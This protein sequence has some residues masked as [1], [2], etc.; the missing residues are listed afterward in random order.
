MTDTSSALFMPFTTRGVTFKNRIVV[1]PM[2]QYAA[3]DGHATDWHFEHYA[4]LALGGV[5]GCVVESTGVL[6]QGRITPGCLGIW[7]DEHVGGLSKIVESFKRQ[8]AAIGLQLGHAGRKGSSATPWDGGR[9]LPEGDPQ[10]WTCEA[11]SAISYDGERPAPHA[12]TVEEI[13]GIVTAFAE[14][15]KRAVAAGFDFVELHGAHGYLIHSFVSPVSNTRDDAY[16]GSAENRMRLPLEIAAA[17]RAALPEEMPLFYRA[18]CIDRLG[19]EGIQLEDTVELARRLKA[20]GVDVMDCSGGGVLLRTNP[21]QIKEGPGFQVGFAERIRAEA[22]IA[23]MAV[24]GITDPAQAE[25]IVAQGRADLCA[26]GKEMLADSN[27]AHRAA[28][29][30]DIE[31]PDFVLPQRYAFYLQFRPRA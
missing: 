25:E 30:L 7:S 23:T 11:P 5:G 14:A 16:G 12:L 24:G 19:D 8:G 13:A 29:A 4:R 6:P 10:G 21:G 22:G 31:K 18:S 17:V 27:F 2:C 20:V 1:S 15:A 3:V 9:G 26:L 28:L